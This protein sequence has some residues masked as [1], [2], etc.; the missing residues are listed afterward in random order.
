MNIS[1]SSKRTIHLYYIKNL[2]ICTKKDE[3]FHLF[4]KSNNEYKKFLTNFYSK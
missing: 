1:V 4:Y 2:K 3:N